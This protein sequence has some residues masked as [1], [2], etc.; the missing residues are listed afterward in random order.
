MNPTQV[1]LTTYDWVPD[2][3]RGHVRDI[4]IRHYCRRVGV[5]QYRHHALLTEGLTCLSSGIVEFGCLP[6][7]NRS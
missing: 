3:P 1:V 7:H 6:Y 2:M 4:R 5:D